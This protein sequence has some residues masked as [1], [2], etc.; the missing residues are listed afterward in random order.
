MVGLSAAGV[1]IVAVFCSVMIYA[2]TG[3]PFWSLARTAFKFFLTRAML[4][5]PTALL[6]GLAAAFGWR[7][8]AL[9]RIMGEYGASVCVVV[10]ALTTLKLAAEASVFASL[11][12]KQFTPLKRTA[13]LMSGELGPTTLQRFAMGLAG[14]VVLPVVLAAP[15]LAKS[16]AGHNPLFVAAAAVL[17]VVLLV[18]GELLERYMFFAA[19]VAPKM[20]GAPAS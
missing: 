8:E 18:M 13:L 9:D 4:G 2:S 1:G 11:A 17:S 14:G 7:G 5:L 20:P 12:S 15:Y 19:V 16:G 6:V 3:R 10:A